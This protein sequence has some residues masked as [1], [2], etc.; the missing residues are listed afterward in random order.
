VTVVDLP[1]CGHWPV[2]GSGDPG[3]AGWDTD[4]ISADFAAALRVWLPDHVQL[5]TT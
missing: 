3:Y 4:A 2:A 1:E 5:K